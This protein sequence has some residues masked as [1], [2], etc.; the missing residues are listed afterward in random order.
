MSERRP[1]SQFEPRSQIKPAGVPSYF[2]PEPNIVPVEQ[3][4]AQSQIVDVSSI[5]L[6]KLPKRPVINHT[7]DPTT[8]I[9]TL[10]PN[11]IKPAIVI[12]NRAIPVVTDLVQGSTTTEATT[13]NCR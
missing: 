12:E 4:Q 6:P 2:L 13:V 7:T 5:S 11:A 1:E 9:R 3:A 10:P 8:V